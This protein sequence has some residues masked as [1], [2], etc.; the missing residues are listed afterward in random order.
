[1]GQ[2]DNYK[3]SI[4]VHPTMDSISEVINYYAS[5]VFIIRFMV[6]TDLKASMSSYQPLC[7]RELLIV[8]CSE[9][10]DHLG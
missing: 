8:T 9:K 5:V 3:T 1:M 10:S 6:V 2:Q 4:G 7:T